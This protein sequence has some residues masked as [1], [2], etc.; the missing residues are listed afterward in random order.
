MVRRRKIKYAQS[1]CR[2]CDEE[3]GRRESSILSGRFSAL[4]T[5]SQHILAQ[6]S[7]SLNPSSNNPNCTPGQGREMVSEER[8]L[9]L[10][11]PR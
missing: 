9:A 8:R 1:V 2:L 7:A 10:L 5:M 4:E 6:A 11:C 3:A